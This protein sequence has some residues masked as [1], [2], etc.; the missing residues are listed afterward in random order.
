VLSR[1]FTSSTVSIHSKTSTSKV[2][3]IICK[4][5]NHHLG[6]LVM[7]R[8]SRIFGKLNLVKLDQSSKFPT[9]S[10]SWCTLVIAK[11]CMTSST[12]IDSTWMPSTKV[13]SRKLAKIFTSNQLQR[14]KNTGRNQSTILGP[15]SRCLTLRLQN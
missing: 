1:V 3:W 6:K 5:F 11:E 15:T 9:N 12:K 14:W 4:L 2:R 7:I 8:F 10:T 13:L